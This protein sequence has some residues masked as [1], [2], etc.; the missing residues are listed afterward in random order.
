MTDNVSQVSV[1]DAGEADVP[2]LTAI[3]GEWSEAIHRDR[4]RDVRE[5]GFRYFVLTAG[6]EVVGYSCLVFQR[7]AYWLDANDT[8]HLP[9]IVD[10]QVDES[11]RGQ[12]F[13]SAFIRAIERITAEAGYHQLYLSVEP[14]DNPRA[15]ALYQR[16]GFQQLQPEPHRSAWEFT[17]SEGVRHHGEDWVVDMVKQLEV[18]G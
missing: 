1:R 5:G 14:D 7:P 3:K 12:G 9:Q 10:L 15:H 18:G 2:A 8:E 16:L 4:L 11:R 17:D 6:E 13:G